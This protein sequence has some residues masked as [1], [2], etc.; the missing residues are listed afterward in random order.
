MPRDPLSLLGDLPDWPGNTPPK[1]RTNAP[2]RM[3]DDDMNG[4]RPTIYRV[5]GEDK[6]FYTIGELARAVGRKAVTIR[7]WEASGWIPKPTYRGS[8]PSGPQLPN[9][10]AK[11]RRLYSREQVEFLVRAVNSFSLDDRNSSDWD[12]FRQFVKTNWPK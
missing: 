7:K 12:K 11:G 6:E 2:R 5:A 9:H 4:A 10:P 8:A 1:N 3:H